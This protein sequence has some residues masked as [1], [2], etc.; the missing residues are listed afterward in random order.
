MPGGGALGYLELELAT[1]KGQGLLR[2]ASSHE[3]ALVLCAND[4]LGYAREPFDGRSAVGHA[5]ASG[6]GGSRLVNG[7]H[8]AHA[9]LERTLA[10][11]VGLEDA[12]LFSSGYAANVGTLAA[13]AGREDVIVSDSLNHASIIDGCRLSRAALKVIPH[14]DLGAVEQALRESQSSRRRFVVTEGYFS[15]DA[16]VPDLVGLRRVCDRYD[17]ALVVDE[18]HSLGIF[19]RE[20]RGACHHAGIVPDVLVGTLG[21]SIGL[22]GAFVAGPR[23]LKAWLWNRARTFVFSTGVSPW[24][25]TLTE[26]RVHQVIADDAGRQRLAAI[27]SHVRTELA[28]AGAPLLPSQGPILPWLVGEPR[29][30]VAFRERLLGQGL[31]VQAIRPPT[32]PVGTSRLRITLHAQLSDA[33]VAFTLAGL[34]ELLRPPR[35]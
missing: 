5:V 1:L 16:D 7:E 24:L 9:A 28:K 4:Y 17:A 29:L 25:S 35:G 6:A 31:F 14:C 34:L 22:Q 21:K 15:M 2:T 8:P 32:V 10:D 33:E 3:G 18:A 13:L 26:A 30:A 23:A 27:V 19:G 12:L 20:G 11:W